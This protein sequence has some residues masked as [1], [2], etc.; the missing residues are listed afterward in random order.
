[1]KSSLSK[2]HP[3]YLIFKKTVEDSLQSI[4]SP[5]DKEI[6]YYVIDLLVKFMMM[7]QIFSL[8]NPLGERVVS[9]S[10]MVAEGDLRLN[11]SSFERERE[12][13]KHIGDFILF[14]TGVYPELLRKM[15]L[16]YGQDLLCDYPRQGKESY[17]IASTFDYEPY[18]K[19]AKIYC[20]LSR[21]FEH[22]VDCLHEV[23]KIID[24]HLV[25]LP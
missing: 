13:H 16:Q 25:S 9:L 10:E 21:E 3:L 1:M 24:S 15:K 11:A 4:Q 2:S 6:E 12:V 17:Y 8:C 22:Y 14:W 18:T 19:E 5:F 7:D 23:R 20:K